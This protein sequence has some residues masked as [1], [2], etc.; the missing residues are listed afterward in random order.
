MCY[1]NFI[2]SLKRTREHSNF[3]AWFVIIVK[4]GKRDALK[5]IQ[6]YQKVKGL[7]TDMLEEET[8]PGIMIL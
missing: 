1:N 6:F 8:M 7:F 4:E 5:Q 2:T 3:I